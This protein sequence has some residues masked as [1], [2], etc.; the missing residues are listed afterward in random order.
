MGSFKCKLPIFYVLT[1]TL[2]FPREHTKYNLP[3]R[4]SPSVVM[5]Y[6]KNQPAGYTISLLSDRIYNPQQWLFFH[7]P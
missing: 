1:R 6:N 7:Q 4:Y 3:H 2:L 5:F